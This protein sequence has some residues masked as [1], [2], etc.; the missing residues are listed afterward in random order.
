MR[1][2]FQDC[3]PYPKWNWWFLCGLWALLVVQC[4][5]ECVGK[6]ESRLDRQYANANVNENVEE[7][8][9]VEEEDCVWEKEEEE[10]E[11]V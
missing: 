11:D 9:D 7:E 2:C 3:P 4:V 1:T 5:W 8:K 10:E 6:R